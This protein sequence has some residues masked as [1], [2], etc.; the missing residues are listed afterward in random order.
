MARALRTVKLVVCVLAA[1][2]AVCAAPA[3]AQQQQ[4]AGGGGGEASSQPPP[5]AAPAAC[6]LPARPT[7]SKAGNNPGKVP[8]AF[9]PEQAEQFIVNQA[10]PRVL[11]HLT[12]TFDCV[13]SR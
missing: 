1:V 13:D 5:P 6:P 8:H 2:A 7:V 12:T 11:N 3:R 4:Q 10:S 9:T